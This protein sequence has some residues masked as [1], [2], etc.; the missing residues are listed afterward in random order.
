MSRRAIVCVVAA[1]LMVTACGANNKGSGSDGGDAK[2]TTTA[3]ATG[4]TGGNFGTLASPCGK[5]TAKVAAADAGQ[6]TDKLYV[7]VANDRT[8]EI[9]PGLLAELWD[10]GVGFAKWCNDQ[11]GIDG[12]K[13]ETVDLDGKLLQIEAAMA[14]ACTGVFA[15]VGGGYAQDNMIFTGKDGS[16]FHKCKMIA[17]PGFAVSTDFAEGNGQVQAIPNPARKK[18]AVWLADLMKL[19]PEK[20]KNLT[21]VFGNL[22][23]IQQNKDQIIATAKKVP[24]YDKLSEIS[25]DAI[26]NQDWGLVAQ[27][28]KDKG[29]TAVSYVGEPENMAKLSQAMK[30]QKVDAIL[31]ADAVGYDQLVIKAAGAPAVEGAIVRIATHPFEEDSKWPATKQLED[32]IKAANPNAKVASLS[33]Q[34][35]SAWLL[36]AT[37]AKACGDK[38]EIS[39]DCVMTELGKIHKWD[40]GGLHAVSDPP[41][42]VPPECSMLV[43]IKDGKFTRLF[44]KSGSADDNGQ[45]FSC[46]APGVVDVTGD[47]GKGNVDPS[48]KN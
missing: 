28:I 21:V 2:A 24:G 39:R 38:G 7:G 15:M 1:A 29:A 4:A 11:G 6:G 37:A 9:R 36:F 26:G 25:Y 45:G 12:L 35:F 43:Q 17:V 13:I 34:A 44:P 46:T 3:A 19:Y 32:T 23:S 16:D 41:S 18:S 40:G 27:Q 22:P 10:A 31:F 5:G 48:R 33:N 30:D 42:N 20:M 8:S 47:F 14:K